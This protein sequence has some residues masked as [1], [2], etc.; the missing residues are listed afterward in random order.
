MIFSVFEC[1]RVF[2]PQRSFK[3]I[4]STCAN[5][6]GVGNNPPEPPGIPPAIALAGAAIWRALDSSGMVPN[7]NAQLGI[8]PKHLLTLN[9]GTPTSP[10]EDG[11]WG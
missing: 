11:S 9:E 7:K 10:G 5:P 3:S 6:G 2:S 4:H 8:R 1:N